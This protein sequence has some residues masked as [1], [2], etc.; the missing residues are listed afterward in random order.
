MNGLGGSVEKSHR[1]FGLR[2]CIIVLY[3]PTLR[4]FYAHHR[5]RVLSWISSF[6]VKCG[7]LLWRSLLFTKSL[8]KGLISK[9][10]RRR[11][12]ESE[13]GG[14]LAGWRGRRLGTLMS[15]DE[16]NHRNGAAL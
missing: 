3:L 13:S 14:R 5:R 12:R 6:F 16:E 4:F 9:F 8:L 2:L 11:R 15:A 1:S 10:E 7:V